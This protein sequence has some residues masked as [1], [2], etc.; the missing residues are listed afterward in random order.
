MARPGLLV[1]VS[2]MSI[3]A[4][5]V[6]GAEAE[7]AGYSQKDDCSPGTEVDGTFAITSTRPYVCENSPTV[8]TL[9]LVY[10]V[11]KLP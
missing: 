9:P 10:W 7:L 11:M 6:T 1:K 8:A 5:V 2:A 3:S 4:W